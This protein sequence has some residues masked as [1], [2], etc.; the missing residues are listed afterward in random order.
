[1]RFKEF[2][3][4]LADV[5]KDPSVRLYRMMTN[6]VDA[7][8]GELSNATSTDPAAASAQQTS[9]QSRKGAVS[10][11]EVSSY[12]SSKGLDRNHVL[13]ILANIK[14]ES[15]FQPGVAGDGGSSVGLFQYRGSRRTNMIKFVG[16]DWQTDWKGQIDF[17]LSEPEGQQYVK[18]RFTSPAQATAW[19]VKYFERPKHVAADIQTRTGFLS[20]LA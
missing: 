8:S 12:L 4:S 7:V 19:W 1:M 14:G 18:T 11:A 16:S 13:G 15:G 5:E 9:V 10:P 6:P 2:S 3:E 20:Q 17:A